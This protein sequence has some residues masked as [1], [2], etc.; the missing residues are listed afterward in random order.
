MVKIFKKIAGISLFKLLLAL[1]FALLILAF[2][3]FPTIAAGERT[4]IPWGEFRPVESQFTRMDLAGSYRYFD[5]RFA[6][7]RSNINQ[8]QLSFLY[9]GMRENPEFGYDYNLQA[10]LLLQEGWEISSE[11]IGRGNYRTFLG[12]DVD[13]FIYAGGQLDSASP[14]QERV[15]AVISGGGGTGRFYD[16]QPLVRAAR[17]EKRLL[18]EE[19]LTA[20]LG[21]DLMLEMADIIAETGPVS[22]RLN[23][24]WRLLIMEREADF[25]SSQSSLNIIREALE[26]PR[27]ART[28]GREIKAGLGYPLL[29]PLE[30]ARELSLV[31]EA[32]MGYPLTLNTQAN[33]TA[34]LAATVLDTF[35]DI[36]F[37][38]QGDIDHRLTEDINLRGGINY[39]RQ[40]W[41]GFPE[42]H[43]FLSLSG[44]AVFHIRENLSITTA[45]R[46][47][48]HTL[49]EEPVYDFT[50][51]FTLSVF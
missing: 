29:A 30:R 13:H 14:L 8:G 21:P 7:D 2:G 19:L 36:T 39:S 27:R 25:I 28:Y 15:S 23:E 5:D 12:E 38:I 49:Y 26:E 4:A 50:T 35:D 6:D 10:N 46:R 16:V 1:L 9:R 20:A 32:R 37:R 33:L 51:A 47:S 18:E 24:I 31:A 17:I 22:T 11:G 42:T 48:S 3:I 44:S 45:L 43:N 41:Q 40:K 34:S